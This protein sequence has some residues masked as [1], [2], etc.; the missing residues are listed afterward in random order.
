MTFHQAYKKFEQRFRNKVKEEK[1]IFLPFVRPA[2][3]VDYVLVGMESSLGR[4]ASSDPCRAHDEAHKKR[5]QGMKHFAWS[6]EDFILHHCIRNYLCQGGETYYL[7]DLSKGAMLTKDAAGDR[8]AR[9]EKWYPILEEEIGLIAKPEAKII[10]IGT[11]VGT[12]L[13]EKALYRHAGT[14]LHYSTQAAKYRGREGMPESKYLE[15]ASSVE[16]C[17]VLQTAEQVLEEGAVCPSLRD[18]ILKRLKRSGLSD[19][20][21]RLMFNYK[22]RFGRIRRQAESGWLRWQSRTV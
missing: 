20:R 5:E 1:T 3:P 12:F 2:G 10:S 13:S 4:W 9:Y 21:K 11:V 19:S 8:R 17:H 6:M 14:I 22:I 7:T 15:F 16:L 18:D